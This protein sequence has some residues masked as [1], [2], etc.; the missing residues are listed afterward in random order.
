[1]SGGAERLFPDAETE[2]IM[3]C[4]VEGDERRRDSGGLSDSCRA[5][6]FVHPPKCMPPTRLRDQRIPT[7]NGIRDLDHDL[8]HVSKGGERAIKA[9]H[10]RITWDL[11]HTYA[12]KR[13]REEASAVG[14]TA[15]TSH[16][17]HAQKDSNPACFAQNSAARLLMKWDTGMYMPWYLIRRACE[18]AYY[19]SP[20]SY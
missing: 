3:S 4:R 2:H 5:G 8:S 9:G 7:Q 12:P 20:N 11:V 19:K 1:M 16:S 17:T 10:C 14:E 13:A 15:S 18:L 6:G